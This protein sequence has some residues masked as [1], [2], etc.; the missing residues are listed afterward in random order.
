MEQRGGKKSV[1]GDPARSLP[2]PRP[3]PGSPD[4]I[5]KAHSCGAGY[6]IAPL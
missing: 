4:V 3:S 6:R 5:N 2:Q 1:P